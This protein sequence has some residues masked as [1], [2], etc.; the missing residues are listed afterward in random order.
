MISVVRGKTPSITE[1]ELFSYVIGSINVHEKVKTDCSKMHALTFFLD[2]RSDV[3]FTDKKEVLELQTVHL[4][5]SHQDTG[6]EK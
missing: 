3:T 4:C 2:N 6:K 5:L 1:E